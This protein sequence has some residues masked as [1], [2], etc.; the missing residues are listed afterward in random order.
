MRRSPSEATISDTADEAALALKTD[1]K[2]RLGVLVFA[3][4][5][6]TVRRGIGEQARL[7][8]TTYCSASLQ[9]VNI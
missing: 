9:T 4:W 1:G 5:G 8:P 7:Y 6:S 2:T 3:M